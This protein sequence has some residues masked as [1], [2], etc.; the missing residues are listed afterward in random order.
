[1]CYSNNDTINHNTFTVIDRM[2][3]GEDSPP[4]AI[5]APDNQ[6]ILEVCTRNALGKAIA[7]GYMTEK[8]VSGKQ[9]DISQESVTIVLVN[10]HKVMI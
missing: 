5:A 10:V 2:W 3:N 8:V 6:G 1:M 9:I 4:G 7:N